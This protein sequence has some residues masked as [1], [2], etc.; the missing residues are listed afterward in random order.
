VLEKGAAHDQPSQD[1]I[2][3]VAFWLG[4]GCEQITSRT[5]SGDAKGG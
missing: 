3:A 2:D 5:A 4:S 1:G